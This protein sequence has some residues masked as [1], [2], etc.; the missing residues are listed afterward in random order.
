MVLLIYKHIDGCYGN[1]NTT[2]EFFLPIDMVI[3][4]S[5]MLIMYLT[6]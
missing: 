3:I 1:N 6:I 5:N 2:S 4:D